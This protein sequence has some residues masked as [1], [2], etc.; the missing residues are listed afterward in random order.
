MQTYLYAY[1]F[2]AFIIGI[3]GNINNTANAKAKVNIPQNKHIGNVLETNPHLAMPKAIF[4][5]VT[6]PA[7]M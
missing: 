7:N 4:M 6:K 5:A 2:S 1:S 3:I